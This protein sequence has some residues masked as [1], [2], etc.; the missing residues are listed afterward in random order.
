M[1]HFTI[2]VK[3]A[4]DEDT[5]PEGMVD[6]LKRNVEWC[7]ARQNMLNDQHQEAI[8]EDWKVT[9]EEDN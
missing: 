3:V 7:V 4:Y 2:T 6:A 5:V 9:V 1:K 8:V